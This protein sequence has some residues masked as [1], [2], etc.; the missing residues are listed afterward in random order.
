[1]GLKIEF[2]SLEAFLYTLDTDPQ[3]GGKQYEKSD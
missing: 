3:L 2:E 1:M